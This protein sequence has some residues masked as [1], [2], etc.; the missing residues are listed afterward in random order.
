MKGG[1]GMEE[2]KQCKESLLASKS[3]YEERLLEERLNKDS[4]IME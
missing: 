2:I 3:S 4:E 1:E